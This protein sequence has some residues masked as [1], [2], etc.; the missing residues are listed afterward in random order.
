VNLPE[1]LQRRYV[2]SAV[3]LVA[4]SLLGLSFAPFGWWPLAIL[5]PAALIYLWDGATPRRAAALGFWFNF[6]TFAVGTYWLYISL[7]LIGH[8]PVPLALLLMVGLAAIMGAYHALLGWT[9]AKYFPARGPVRWLIAIPGAWLL[10]EWFRSWFLSGF[11]WLAL[12]YAHTDNW[13][14]SLA[15]VIGQFGLGLITVVFA[16]AAVTL[17]LGTRR[18]R[19][20]AVAIVVIVTG[21]SFALSGVEWTQVSGKPIS[22]AVVQ[23]AT[24]QDEKW[25][26]DKA[27]VPKI[28]D[29]FRTLTV[30]AHGADLIVWPEST[31]PDL[32]NYHVDYLR[33]VYQA[34]SATGSALVLGALRAQVNPETNEEEVFNSVLVWDP[35]TPGVGF[36]DKHHLVPFTEFFPVPGF[37]RD[38]L[39]LMELPYSDFNRGAAFQPPL[40]AA[41][42]KI[43]IGICY[44][45]AYGSTQLPALRTAT[46]LVNVTNDSWFARSTARYQHLQISRLRALEAGRP[47]VRAANDG[48]SA[49]IGANG[50][51]LAAAPE[52]EATVMRAQLQPRIGLTPYART[53]NWPVVLL[54]LVF[55][56]FGAYLGG[57]RATA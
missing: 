41:G 9:I 55:G 13:L 21:T 2:G 23:G 47:M 18:A 31:I 54:A 5:C 51:I 36:Y 22:V 45:D 17:A 49:V 34:A 39:R 1:I 3:A 8:A 37:I 52:Y 50:K 42:Q 48:V 15:P 7:Q 44:E 20:A 32:I 56:L 33:E 6:G 28:L 19:V 30:Q 16:G 38:W 35:A 26:E 11:G 53:G 14:G 25:L 27:S 40:D 12:G 29:T 4:G 24:P 10:I 43:A 57:R 46:L